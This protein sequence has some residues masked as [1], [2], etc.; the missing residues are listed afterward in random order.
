MEI[1]KKSTLSTLSYIPFNYFSA[2]QDNSEQNDFTFKSGIIN[3]RFN[4]F[5]EYRKSYQ[6]RFFHFLSDSGCQ[7]VFAVHCNSFLYVRPL[8]SASPK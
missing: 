3:D 6:R 1:I 8:L 5:N 2:N 4:T 7:T